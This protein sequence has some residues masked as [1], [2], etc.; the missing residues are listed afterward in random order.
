MLGPRTPDRT[1]PSV[2]PTGPSRA[3]GPP[4]EP[5]DLWVLAEGSRRGATFAR[6]AVPV[7]GSAPSMRAFQLALELAKI[8]HSS[9]A[10]ITVIPTP[11]SYGL[12][13]FPPETWKEITK[14][15]EDELKKLGERARHHG[16]QQVTWECRQG[17]VVDEVLE[18]LRTHPADLVVVGARGLSASRRLI[19][20]SVSDGLVHHAT[21]PVLVVRDHSGG[22]TG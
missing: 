15:Y 18:F 11:P 5:A 20:G 10:L 2:E 14:A 8:F 4:I 17:V 9:L 16:I 6:I 7:D 19:L 12:P 1:A 3:A 21:C 22:G 13:F